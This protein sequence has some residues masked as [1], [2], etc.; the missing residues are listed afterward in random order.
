[1]NDTDVHQKAINDIKQ[2]LSKETLLAYPDFNKTFVIHPDAS[3]VQLGG[4]I[5]QDNHP[6]AFYSR[7][8]NPAQTRYTTTECELLSIV[9][10][11]KEFKNIL[12]GH[13]IQVFTDHENLTYKHFNTERVMRWRLI[14]EEFGPTL[15]H[16]PGKDNVVADALSQLPIQ[17]QTTLINHKIEDLFGAEDL[18]KDIFPLTYPL[19]RKYQCE[20]DLLLQ[21]VQSNDHYIMKPFHGGRKTHHLI[22]K[23]DRICLPEALQEHAVH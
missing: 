13:K 23:H 5:S 21:K 9:E 11:L 19:I 17:S 10:I 4:V 18:P 6:I 20:D 16:I 12:L 15:T 3:A 1:M 8:L 7:K 22:C 14:L 2:I